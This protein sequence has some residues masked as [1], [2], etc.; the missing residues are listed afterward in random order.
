MSRF[1]VE[2]GEFG[3]VA[4]AIL[5]AHGWRARTRDGPNTLVGSDVGTAHALS[6]S[7]PGRL[8]ERH[9]AAALLVV[10]TCATAAVTVAVAG[11]EAWSSIPAV[12]GLCGL[13]WSDL[14]RRR[15]PRVAVRST[16]IA[17]AAALV[18]QSSVVGSW[19]RLVRASIAWVAVGGVLLL[20]WW[21]A[22][23][24]LAFGDVRVAAL[25]GAAAGAESWAALG[26]MMP[27]VC[28]AGG[29]VTLVLRQIASAGARGT[30]GM[31]PFVPGLFA[32]F[33]VGVSMC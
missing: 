13:A 20:V 10:A 24:V 3:D 31:I 8:R 12:C 33:T 2:V 17:M 21:A 14:R 9:G 30:P 28:V 27:A 23:R 16:A 18:V 7:S 25:T 22:P 29:V 15:L 1:P 4:H 19:H 6:E 5:T 11:I 26:S 32:G